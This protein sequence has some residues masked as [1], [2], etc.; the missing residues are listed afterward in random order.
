MSVRPTP[1]QYK[2]SRAGLSLHTA[3]ADDWPDPTHT[4]TQ[5]HTL[6]HSHV[7]HTHHTTHSQRRWS[8]D[9]RWEMLPAGSRWVSPLS[10]LCALLSLLCLPLLWLPFCGPVWVH[11]SLNPSP[12]SPWNGQCFLRLRD[13]SNFS[14]SMPCT[15]LSLLSLPF[16]LFS[17]CERRQKQIPDLFACWRRARP[18]CLYIWI[19][20]LSVWMLT[21]H[22]L[23]LSLCDIC[24]LECLCGLLSPVI[25]LARLCLDLN[26][27]I[28]LPCLSSNVHS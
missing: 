27:S 26:I 4:H 21:C 6:T 10:L 25:S 28:V 9:Q 13:F 16:F 7:T 1:I 18:G 24:L 17:A 20:E 5:R 14:L 19:T 11:L 3:A 22:I 23:I 2:C 15:Y 12:L 8:S